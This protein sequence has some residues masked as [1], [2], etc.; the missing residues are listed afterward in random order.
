MRVVGYV[1][2]ATGMETGQPAFAQSEKIRRWAANTGHQLV[3]ICQDVRTPGRALGREGFRAMVGIVAAGQAD[4]V[5]VPDLSALSADKVTQEV[6]IWDLRRRE[7]A[8]LSADDDESEQLADPPRDQLRLIVRDVLAKA[9][10]HEESLAFLSELPPTHP[11]PVITL[12]DSSD[13]IV[14]LIPA[15]ATAALPQE[16]LKPAR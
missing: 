5:I 7:V 1:R 9:T 3:A 13:V 15:P 11:E 12:E 14:E 4:G 8:V 10:R 2:E 6:V 16:I